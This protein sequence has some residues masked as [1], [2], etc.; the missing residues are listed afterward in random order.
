[1]VKAYGSQFKVKVQAVLFIEEE[2]FETSGNYANSE[3]ISYF[4][5]NGILDRKEYQPEKSV[6][7]IPLN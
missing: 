5:E 6:V 4:I 3:K 2:G 1:M 7:V